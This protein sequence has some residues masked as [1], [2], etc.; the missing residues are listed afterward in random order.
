[1]S[2]KIRITEALIKKVEQVFNEGAGTLTRPQLR[3]LHRKGY[4]ARKA[5][6]RTGGTMYYEYGLKSNF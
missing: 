5:M 1:M 2:K 3:A 6:R 4:L